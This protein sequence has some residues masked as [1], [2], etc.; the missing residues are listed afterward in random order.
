MRQIV[1]ERPVYLCWDMDVFD[2]SVA[3][4]VF[5]PSWGGI[6]PAAGFRL[7]RGLT[8]LRIVAADIDTVSR[9]TTSTT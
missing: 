8:G 1:G 4:G 2:P 3:P 9:P 7:V 6:S 5:S